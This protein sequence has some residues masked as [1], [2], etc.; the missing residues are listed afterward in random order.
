LL[1]VIFNYS[2]NCTEDELRIRKIKWLKLGN[3]IWYV[4]TKSDLIYYKN[5]YGSVH[6]DASE[7]IFY[8]KIEFIRDLVTYEASDAETL[9]RH[10]HEAVDEYLDDCKDSNKT[11][12]KPFKGS[13]NVRVDPEL[14]KEA[15]LYALQHGDTLNGVVR[16]ALNVF[17]K[18]KI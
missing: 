2:R 1:V 5:Y 13:F 17:I 18:V 12:D 3:L 15:S 16:K 10:F 9:I 4:T 11:P 8:G 6:F 7:K 14:H